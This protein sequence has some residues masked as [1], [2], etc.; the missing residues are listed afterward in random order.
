MIDRREAVWTNYWVF[1]RLKGVL[2]SR[3]PRGKEQFCSFCGQGIQNPGVL[4]KLEMWSAI[5]RTSPRKERVSLA[6]RGTGQSKMRAT[7]WGLRTRHL[8]QSHRPARQ[9]AS[10]RQLALRSPR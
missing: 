5:Y 8:I 7:K 3:C 2:V 9:M 10:Q 4:R 6:E 1:D